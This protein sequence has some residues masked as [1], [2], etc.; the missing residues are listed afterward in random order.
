MVK[1]RVRENTRVIDNVKVILTDTITRKQ[2]VFSCHNI[3]LNY[4]FIAMA[5]WIGW[6]NNFGYQCVP[7]PS[8]IALGSGSGVPAFGDAGLFAAIVGA[9][10]PMSYCQPNNPAN[11]TTTFMF[12]VP[13]GLVTTQVTEAIM[14]DTNGNNWAHA[15]FSVPFTPSAAENITI[16][17]ELTFS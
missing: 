3:P 15:M 2:R 6:V 7:P 4:A 13:A 14:Q 9:I 17:W 5:N 16:Q 10:G 8:Q 1:K 11:G 12:Q